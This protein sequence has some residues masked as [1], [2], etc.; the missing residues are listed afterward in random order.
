MAFKWNELNLSQAFQPGADLWMVFSQ[1]PQ[2]SRI[3]KRFDWLCNFQLT[4]FVSRTKPSL[5]A[6]QR[7]SLVEY[8]IQFR[9]LSIKNPHH[10]LVATHPYFFNRWSYFCSS[11]TASSQDPQGASPSVS[12]RVQADLQVWHSLNHP[13][14]RFFFS[15]S[16]DN[17]YL[18]ALQVELEKSDWSEAGICYDI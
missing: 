12:Q 17:T 18:K 1:D 2:T 6:E 11:N 8:G 4:K 3:W 9:D 15:Q 10:L 13:R 5:S 7:K 14:V 16:P